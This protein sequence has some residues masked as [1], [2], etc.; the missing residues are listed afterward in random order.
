[1]FHEE[2]QS[3]RLLALGAL[4]R[5]RGIRR[6]SSMLF[7]RYSAVEGFGCEFEE[8]LLEGKRKVCVGAS[9]PRSW[10]MS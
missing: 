9:D 4:P 7:G 1:M 10:F 6:L 5:P 3:V 8:A 2:L